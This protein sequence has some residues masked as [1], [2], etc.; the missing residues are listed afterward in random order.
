MILG[1]E[2]SVAGHRDDRGSIGVLVSCEI[3][4]S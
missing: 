2:E 4:A 1:K 3:G